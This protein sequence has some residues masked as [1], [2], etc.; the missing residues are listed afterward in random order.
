MK[1]TSGSSCHL[2]FAGEVADDAFGVTRPFKFLGFAIFEDLQG[3][4]PA[5]AV[6][7]SNRL[8][9][10]LIKIHFRKPSV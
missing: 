5:D 8:V 9:L 1:K 4:V 6:L 3:G 10:G 7:G 2:A